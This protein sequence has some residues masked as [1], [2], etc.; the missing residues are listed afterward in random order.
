MSTCTS[1]HP[2]AAALIRREQAQAGELLS[3]RSEM[4]LDRF[5]GGLIGPA[6]QGLRRAM[7]AVGRVI[8]AV[9][10]AARPV[11]TRVAKQA[12]P[13]LARA[14]RAALSAADQASGDDSPPGADEELGGGSGN[15]ASRLWGTH[16]Q[17]MR[18]REVQMR[19]ASRFV[20]VVRQATRRAALGTLRMLR[21]GRPV[22]LRDVQRLVSSAILGAARRWT[23]WL[24]PTH[25]GV[26]VALRRAPAH[27]GPALH[28]PRLGRIVAV[29][30]PRAPRARPGATGPGLP[31]PRPAFL[32][33]P[34]RAPAAP[35][36]RRPV[37]APVPRAPAAP[38]RP[39]VRPPTVGPRSTC[40]P[41]CPCF[42]CRKARDYRARA[43][44]N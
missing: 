40:G 16:F 18:P 17:R 15:R 26:A 1:H 21:R 27:D 32:G 22:G 10:R 2:R 25:T 14:G 23:P 4:E 9:G 42:R 33:A 20:R 34:A 5:L 24:L 41:A 39:G 7:P 6:L 38:L 19:M 43:Q 3:V 35:V 37:A 36:A 30:A 12:L 29:A 8:G 44:G 28:E 11:L 13:R 31:T